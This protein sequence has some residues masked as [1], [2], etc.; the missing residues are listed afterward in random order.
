MKQTGYQFFLTTSPSHHWNSM[1]QQFLRLRQRKPLRHWF[2]VC[3]FITAF[4]RFGRYLVLCIWCKLE[5]F[6]KRSSSFLILNTV[7]VNSNATAIG[8]E[9]ESL[10]PCWSSRVRRL[11]LSRKASQ[12]NSFSS[13]MTMPHL[14][15]NAGDTWNYFRTKQFLVCRDVKRLWI[16]ILKVTYVSQVTCFKN[17]FSLGGDSEFFARMNG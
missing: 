6:F 15:N 16:V 8:E 10:L 13:V 17:E 12:E 7:D 3:L 1:I 11:Q 5:K 14:D 4:F 2:F 9:S